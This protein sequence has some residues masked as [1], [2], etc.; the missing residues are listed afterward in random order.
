MK[1]AISALSEKVLERGKED[2]EKGRGHFKTGEPQS[3]GQD[4][5][6]RAPLRTPRGPGLTGRPALS[7][8]LSGRGFPARMMQGKDT[9]CLSSTRTVEA[10]LAICGGAAGRGASV[11]SLDPFRWPS[12]G[13]G[14]SGSIRTGD[15]KGSKGTLFGAHCPRGKGPDASLAQTS[16]THAQLPH[17][18]F[19]SRSTNEP[20]PVTRRRTSAWTFPKT[21]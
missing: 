7:Q 6:V 16:G 3:G 12:G 20:C 21:F 10:L 13:Q 17:P 2:R 11:S 4:V 1:V 15:P 18:S 19:L 8:R 5:N 9:G 14:T